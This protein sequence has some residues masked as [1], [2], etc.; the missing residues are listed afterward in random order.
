MLKEALT[1]CKAAAVRSGVTPGTALDDKLS[2]AIIRKTSLYCLAA[3]Y[4]ET[5]TK[6]IYF[7][8]WK[9]WS[10]MVSD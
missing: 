6:G 2:P 3:Q 8:H 9:E 10:R 1:V 7:L 5:K 4:K